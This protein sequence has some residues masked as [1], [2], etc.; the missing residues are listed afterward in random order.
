[1][2]HEHGHFTLGA[3]PEDGGVRFGVWAPAAQRVE[4]VL[5]PNGKLQAMDRD[6]RGYFHS[7]VPGIGAGSLYRYRLDGE[8]NFPDPASRFQPYGVHGVSEVVDPYA[9]EWQDEGWQGVPHK[10]LV[11]YELHVGTFTP[12]GSFEAARQKLSHLKQL[13]ITALELMPLADFPGRWNWG[14]DVAA[15]FAPARCYGRPDELRRLVDEAHRLGLAVYLDV[16]YNH[17][18]PDGAYAAA[19]NPFYFTERH[20]TPWGQAINLDGQHS[21]SVRQF[22]LANALHWLNEYRLDG[23]RLDATHALIDDGKQHFLAELSAV[24]AGLQEPRRHL[25]AEDERNFRRLIEP[26]ETG[27]YG[28]DAVWADDFHHQV[29]RAL[30]GD[31]EGYYRDFS[32]S[33]ED[34]AKTIEQGW[35]FTGQH[36]EH[37][38]GR[39]DAP[40]DESRRPRPRRGRSRQFRGVQS[41]V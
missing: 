13:G 29:R 35:F 37:L 40:D 34:T 33:T 8:S 41:G 18:G 11:F 24:V 32:G 28:L 1:M 19:L 38:G 30:A 36:S 26:R 4:V 23:L 14:Y 31:S 5:E 6:N 17:L 25:I 7:F 27:G 22:L 3:L 9:Y 10:D 16:V 12:E 15:L 2:S 20:H 39:R 21:E